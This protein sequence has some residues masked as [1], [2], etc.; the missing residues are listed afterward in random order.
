MRTIDLQEPPVSVVT[1][2]F[3]TAPYLEECIQ[4]VVAQTYRNWR[5]ILV[6][7]Q[8]TDGSGDIA[9]GYAERYPDNIRLVR[10][11]SFLSQ[12]ENYNFALSLIGEKSRYCKIVQADDSIDP[13]CLARMVQEFEKS[14]RIGLVGAYDFKAGIVR[15]ARFPWDSSPMNGKQAARLYLDSGV[16]PFGSP[17]SVMYRSSIV[18]ASQPFFAEGRLHEDTEKCMEILEEWDFG[19]VYQVLAFIRSDNESI[20]AAFRR[21]SPNAIDRYLIV[22]RFADRFLSP[23]EAARL[24]SK[25]KQEYYRVLANAVLKRYPQPFWEHHRRGLRMI[26]ESID[27]ALLARRVASQFLS[28]C[29]NPGRSLDRLLRRGQAQS[30]L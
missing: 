3:N 13:T 6:D 8:S 29:L 22:R 7:N 14:N 26:G 23:A 11:P 15:G 17:T 4:S 30:N 18:R 2:F 10:T 19:F 21:Y 24:Q 9:A 25:E 16:F 28:A 20:S 12:V 1:P 27:T 5:Y